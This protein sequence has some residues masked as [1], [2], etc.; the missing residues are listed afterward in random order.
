M[1]FWAE[2][3]IFLILISRRELVGNPNQSIFSVPVVQLS[4]KKFHMAIMSLQL[5]YWFTLFVLPSICTHL[6]TSSGRTSQL[7]QVTV[8]CPKTVN[9]LDERRRFCQYWPREC[10]LTADLRFCL[11]LAPSNQ[12]IT[13]LGPLS[14]NQIVDPLD[15]GTLKSANPRAGTSINQSDCGS[16]GSL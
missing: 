13:E 16:A 5:L 8:I 12:P 15:L 4:P 11:V 14:T 10:N 6:I 3:T 9:L 1:T 2:I 7:A